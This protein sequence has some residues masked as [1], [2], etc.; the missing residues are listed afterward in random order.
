MRPV[1]PL[2]ASYDHLQPEPVALL[3]GRS[4]CFPSFFRRLA[5]G[6]LPTPYLL[7]IVGFNTSGASWTTRRP[8]F[9]GSVEATWTLVV[10]GIISG[11]VGLFYARLEILQQL[12]LAA[13][14][15]LLPLM[16]LFL[17]TL[18]AFAKRAD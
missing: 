10:A 8:V 14:E 1:V 18:N 7:P 5:R 2:P 13:L 15:L 4:C 3:P 12:G 6:L 11:V 17:F 16:F 9:Q